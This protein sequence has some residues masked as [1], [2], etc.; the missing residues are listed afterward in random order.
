MLP[1]KLITIYSIIVDSF[2]D[3]QFSF[4]S[5]DPIGFHLVLHEGL[6]EHTSSILKP[7]DLLCTAL[8][9]KSDKLGQRPLHFTA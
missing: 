1:S 8:S 6:T 2:F 3:K 7:L 5:K 9:V 4:L